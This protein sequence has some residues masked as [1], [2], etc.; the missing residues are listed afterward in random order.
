LLTAGGRVAVS[1]PGADLRRRPVYV[2]TMA[3]AARLSAVAT[4]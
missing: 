4:P 2:H 1:R 3:T